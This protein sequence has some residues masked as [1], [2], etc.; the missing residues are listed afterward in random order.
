MN[1]QIKNIL[2]NLN[3]LNEEFKLVYYGKNKDYFINIISILINKEIY[4]YSTIQKDLINILFITNYDFKIDDLINQIS[5]KLGK[6]NQIKNCK[7]LN[8]K[9]NKLQELEPIIPDYKDTGINSIEVDNLPGSEENQISKT[10]RDDLF[11]P[12]LIYDNMFFN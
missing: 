7:I 3:N 2:N 9:T 5:F 11:L 4:Y 6:I 12:I 1:T 10:K 8:L